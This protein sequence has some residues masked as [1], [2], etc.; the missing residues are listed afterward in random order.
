MCQYLFR[1]FILSKL[2]TAVY[3]YLCNLRKGAGVAWGCVMGE[4]CGGG[5]WVCALV[6]CAWL[7]VR[8]KILRLYFG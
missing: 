7:L 4:G 6:Y 8:R 2:F 5:R 3:V 1:D